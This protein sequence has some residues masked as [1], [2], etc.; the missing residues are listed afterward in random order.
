MRQNW[1]VTLAA[2]TIFASMSVS[3][4][5]A[6]LLW[7]AAADNDAGNAANWYD[8]GSMTFGTAPGAA[9]DILIDSGFTDGTGSG[10]GTIRANGRNNAGNSSFGAGGGGR[11][12]V[13][14]TS[15]AGFGG[16]DFQA[17]G[18]TDALGGGVDRRGA[19][20]TVYLQDASQ[21]SGTGSV[22][23][24]NNNLVHT[25][26]TQI[27]AAT[28]AVAGELSE[29]SV[30]LTEEARLQLTGDL[31]VAEMTLDLGT[32]L[33]LGG[34]RL[35]VLGF[36]DPDGVRFDDPGIYTDNSNGAFDGVNFNGGEIEIFVFVPEPST[37]ALLGLGLIP[38]VRRTKRHRSGR[39]SRLSA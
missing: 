23:I 34:N 20:G 17:F 33:D 12:V 26:F 18:G 21:A 14:L 22:T 6:Q 11:V 4:H 13:E 16:I 19:A 36:T 5:A 38:I 31:E 9:D 7:T 28:G 39:S 27:P 29:A 1:R 25:A 37:L 2:L 32:L 8:T 24:G 15:G 35:T 30:F 3:A 10:S